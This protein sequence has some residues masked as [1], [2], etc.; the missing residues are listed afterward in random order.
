MLSYQAEDKQD[1]QGRSVNGKSKVKCL[2][3]LEVS[4]FQEQLCT[5]CHRNII[6]TL[7]AVTLLQIHRLKNTDF[8]GPMAFPIMSK[9]LI[10]H[11]TGYDFTIPTLVTSAFIK[12]M[13]NS[14]AYF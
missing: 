10:A 3:L 11:Y 12:Y 1:L 6:P 7:I 5:C 8:K 14:D 13:L 4:E 2:D 9:V